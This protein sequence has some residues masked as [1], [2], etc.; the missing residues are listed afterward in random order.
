M[1]IGLRQFDYLAIKQHFRQEIAC[2]KIFTI[3]SFRWY[4]VYIVQILKLRYRWKC[5]AQ[6]V[7]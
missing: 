5:M 4:S 3:V 6:D 2:A 1:E 7:K